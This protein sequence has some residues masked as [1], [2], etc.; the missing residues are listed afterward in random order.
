[1]LADGWGAA[2]FYLTLSRSAASAPARTYGVSF[3]T[4]RSQPHGEGK[5]GSFRDKPSLGAVTRQQLGLVLGNLDELAFEGF[6]DTRMKRASRLAQEAV[7]ICHRVGRPRG[8]L[9]RTSPSVMAPPTRNVL[10]SPPA[11]PRSKSSSPRFA[12]VT[13]LAAI[14]PALLI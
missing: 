7:G 9:R 4:T 6:G 3:A 5:A 14:Q 10:R 1:M 2:N 13:T 12:R 8:G 11:A